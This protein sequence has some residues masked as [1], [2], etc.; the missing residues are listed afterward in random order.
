MFY[1]LSFFPLKVF[2]MAETVAPGAFTAKD[3]IFPVARIPVDNVFVAIV[4]GT[5]IIAPTPDF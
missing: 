1:F 3:A 2:F 4:R 5:P